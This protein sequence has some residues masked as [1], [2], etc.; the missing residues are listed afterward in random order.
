MEIHDYLESVGNQIRSGGFKI[1]DYVIHKALTKAPEQ[2]PKKGDGQPH[3]ITA[4][5]MNKK[6][7]GK[8]KGKVYQ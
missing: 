4:L 2:Y 5:R 6:N 8:Y 3:V 1:I 7:P